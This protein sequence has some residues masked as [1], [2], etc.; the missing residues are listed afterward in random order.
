MLTGVAPWALLGCAVTT[1]VEAHR[2]SEHRLGVAEW[3]HTVDLSDEKLSKRVLADESDQHATK[4]NRSLASKSSHWGRRIRLASEEAHIGSIV[5]VD[6][7]DGQ[8]AP[9]LGFRHDEELTHV[10]AEE[11]ADCAGVS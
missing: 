1:A 6:C 10:T 4:D 2:R 7:I 8:A 9:S 3:Q 11:F 5:V